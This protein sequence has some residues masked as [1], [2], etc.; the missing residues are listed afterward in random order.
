MRLAN[1]PTNALR[2]VTD[3]YAD[4][5]ANAPT[6]GANARRTRPPIPPRAFVCASRA[7]STRTQTRFRWRGPRVRVLPIDRIPSGQPNCTCVRWLL[8]RTR[9][10][11]RCMTNTNLAKTEPK[12][13]RERPI[14]KKL[15]QVI[16]ALL[17]GSCKSQKIACERFKLSPS[18]LS[19]SL[20]KDKIRVYLAR[21]T[22]ETIAASQL[23]ATATVLRLLESAKSEHVMFD[24]AK[25]MM[26]LNGYHANPTAPGVNINIGGASA[27]Y[28]IQ[29]AA[30]GDEVLEGE[31]GPNGGVQFGRKLSDTERRTGQLI[32]QH[33]GRTIDVSPNRAAE[34]PS[35][36]PK[37]RPWENEHD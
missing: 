24:A 22:S 31:V 14:T 26:A 35:A 32:P 27:G 12:P 15:V 16:D 34:Q 30:P 6:N 29:L 21:R 3:A 9:G 10:T 17:D 4:A 23:P 33:P 8:Q 13:R 5:Y 18:Y 11:P 25:H 20:K 2:A 28:I 19:R 7:H 36:E 37:R 1:A